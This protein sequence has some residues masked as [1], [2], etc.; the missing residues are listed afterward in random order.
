MND[1]W[2]IG[3]IIFLILVGMSVF[4]IGLL[5][6]IIFHS[7]QNPLFKDQISRF[8]KRFQP[9]DEFTNAQPIQKVDQNLNDFLEQ[10]EYRLEKQITNQIKNL[11]HNKDL[12]NRLDS[13]QK[14]IH[15]IKRSLDQITPTQPSRSNTESPYQSP[16]AVYAPD[17]PAM[18]HH[19][20]KSSTS[21]IEPN[22]EDSRQ[23]AI[24]IYRRFLLE[25]PKNLPFLFTYAEFDSGRSLINQLEGEIYLRFK[26]SSYGQSVF[27]IFFQDT[28]SGWLFPNAR[29]GFSDAMGRVFPTLSPD[30]YDHMKNS[31][32]PL[33]VFSIDGELWEA[34]R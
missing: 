6:V 30:S 23:S 21:K 12:V 28:E 10:L 1:L 14:D 7:K 25:G 32:S 11:A 3:W 29:R 4:F 20:E 2:I 34:K 17:L 8:F 31:V 16:S 19:S 13:L 24:D 27:I 33:Q 26:K 5:L 18:K 15:L 22:Q 9:Q